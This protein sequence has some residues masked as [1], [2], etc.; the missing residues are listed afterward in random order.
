[1]RDF[2]LYH[3]PAIGF[4]AIILV[5]SSI[6]NPPKPSIEIPNF[7]KIAHFVEYFLFSI[8]VFRSLQRLFLSSPKRIS[9]LFGLLFVSLFAG[10]DEYRQQFV[11][12][13]FCDGWDY[14]TDI[15]SALCASLL[16][17]SVRRVK[18]VKNS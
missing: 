17:F 14:L 9:L 15:S 5:V 2:V 7:D 4:A 3:L 1:M 8:L 10:I 12:G 13:R 11:P 16:F 18:R 6:S